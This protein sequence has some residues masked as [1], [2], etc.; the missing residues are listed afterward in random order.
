MSTNIKANIQYLNSCLKLRGFYPLKEQ[1][2]RIF[3]TAHV[4]DAGV[5]L[6][7]SHTS[8]AHALASSSRCSIEG[9]GNA[10]VVHF[11]LFVH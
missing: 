3:L 1:S 4:R 9:I 5:R 10:A 11:P 2:A 8:T 6:Y 7:I